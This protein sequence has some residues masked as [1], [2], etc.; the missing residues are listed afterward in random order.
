M[1]DEIALLESKT[2]R[3][4]VAGRTEAL[5]KVKALTLLPDDMHVTLRMVAAYFGVAD[6]TIH[7]MVTDHREEL[8][9]NG[10]RVAT[11]QE[12]AALKT[13]SSVDRYARQ[14]AL[15]TKRTVL[16]VAMLLRDSV[17]ARQVRTHLLD[18]AESP[19]TEPVDNFFHSLTRWVD[20]RITEALDRHAGPPAS[21][22]SPADDVR[23]AIQQAVLPLLNALMEHD[24]TH[25]TR[26]HA[27]EAEVTRLQR[28]LRERE[29]SASMSTLDA[30]NARQFE[31]HI[32]WLCRRDGCQDVI[33]TGGNG[34]TGA[35][36]VAYT[37]DGRRVVVQCKA[38]NPSHPLTS[39]Q[40][41]HFIGMATLEYGADVALLVTTSTFTRDATLMATRHNVTAVHR[42][43]LKAWHDGAQLH[44]L[45]PLK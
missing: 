39:G 28:V 41:Q 3:A 30:M 9:A 22:A 20:S 10:Y 42:A 38:Y 15:F 16:N 21:T 11:G 24:R 29:S 5:D 32:A 31:Q 25:A 26:L 1:V 23:V 2:L 40:V 18:L 34:D 45:R 4:S 14:A 36:I 8:T 27:L 44:A 6:A 43:L 37:P 13:V 12:L 35:D 33:V 17:V 7:N 19:R